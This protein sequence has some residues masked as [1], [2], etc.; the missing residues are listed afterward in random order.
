[1][2]DRLLTVSL[3]GS[4]SYDNSIEILCHQC[5]RVVVLFPNQRQGRHGNEATSSCGN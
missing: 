5:T 3:P 4:E 1:M 2:I